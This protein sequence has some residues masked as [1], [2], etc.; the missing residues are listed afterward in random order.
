M[1][2]L[3][4]LDKKKREAA[5]KRKLISSRNSL[6]FLA[7]HSILSGLNNLG[8][9]EYVKENFPLQK[10]QK[11]TK[12]D[13][14]K[15]DWE[16][17]KLGVVINLYYRG[18]F[19]GSSG[20]IHS[21][22]NVYD[23]VIQCAYDTAFNDN[24]FPALKPKEAGQLKIEVFL[25]ENEDGII[26]YNDPIELLLLLKSLK[27][28]VIVVRKGRREAYFLPDMWEQIPDEGMVMT[29]LCGQA[30]LPSSAWRGEKRL[31]PKRITESKINLYTGK[32]IPPEDFAGIDVIEKITHRIKGNGK[33]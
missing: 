26:Q 16:K 28:R 9:E 27:D 12:F 19:R 29:S 5:N 3:D 22:N 15:K 13:R 8:F 21:I 31:W 7:R 32:V 14:I 23:D 20:D 2:I 6:L 11:T 10:K 24:R 1:G 25:V 18:N 33:K 30:G 4:K 17:Q